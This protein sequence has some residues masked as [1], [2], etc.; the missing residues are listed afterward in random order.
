MV[1]K[2]VENDIAVL[3]ITNHND[4]SSVSVFRQVA[5]KRGITIFPGF[6]L[7]SQE[8]IHILCLYD[9]ETGEDQL[10]RYLGEFG[11]RQPGVSVELATKSFT[12]ALAVVREQGGL[13]I[14]AHVTNAKGLFKMLSGKSRIKAWQ[15]PDL[16]AIQIPGAVSQLPQDILPIVQNQNPDYR[17]R[18]AAGENLAVAVVNARDVTEPADL[19]N[20]VASCWIKMSEITIEGL[21]QAFLDPDSRI[22]LDSDP[23]PKEHAEIL[24]LTWESGFLDGVT[25]HFNPNLNVL[26]GGRGAGKSTVIESLRYALAQEPSGDDSGKTHDGIV[27]DVL[28]PATKLSLRVRTLRPAPREYL[29][30][31]T[32]P[33]PPT[34]REESGQL[35][36]LQP[37]DILPQVEI[38]GQHEIA[39]VTRSP[40]KRTL[41]LNRFM[42]PDKSLVRR[43]AGVR[44]SLELTRR[45]IQEALFELQHVDQQ[46]TTLPVL[47]EKLAQYQEAGLEDRLQE[48]SLLVREES[49]MDS[50]PER[51]Q[52]FGEA[53]DLLW[54]ELPIN[55]TFLSEKALA[56]L[57][58]RLILAEAV[59][60]LQELDRNLEQ[61][62]IQ[63]AEALGR[64]DKGLA[65]VRENWED[66]KQAVEVEYQRILRDLH[67][68]AV[69]GA[70]FIR[71]RG[72][73]ERLQP[74]QQHRTLLEKQLREQEDRRFALLTEWEDIKAAEF[75]LLD[76]AASYVSRQLR[77]R[78]TIKVTA[79][80]ERESL[81]ETLKEEIGGRLSETLDRIRQLPYLSLPEFVQCCRDGADKLRQ[82]YSIP[83]AQAERL[84]KGTAETL[85]KLE[86]LEL[87]PATE[88][89]LNTAATGEPPVWQALDRLSTGQK[90]TAVLLLLMLES[91]VPLII[92]QPEDDL[93][94]RFITDGVVPGIR[95][96]KR[97]R[98][99]IF[100]THNANIPVLGDAEL[101]LGLTPSGEAYLGNAEI[102]PEHAGSIDAG[103]VRELVEEILEGGKE[104]FETRRLKYGF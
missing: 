46:L 76:R 31:R 22:R 32:V 44:R 66:R 4:V 97:Q 71:L 96:A 8:G 85:M 84:A 98:Q 25:I 33:N 37:M 23:K 48:Q 58:G 104:A 74:L 86:E 63:L 2:A 80:R 17:R 82:T 62:A 59:P 36:H 34:V 6:E 81:C 13:S 52:P 69:D 68:A 92:D 28:R 79:A 19:D 9:H 103:P 42:E 61:I 27:R 60:V 30:E 95:Q 73:I 45:L 20:P 67:T 101:I 5:T 35:S 7:V 26:V 65:P 75:R 89:Q 47:E 38:F 41:L 43:K 39:E 49:V 12:E 14:A 55:L 56:E 90:A 15:S 18:H 3:A 83:L 94:N 91:E 87:L 29:I 72:D 24:S 1:E 70:D 77:N 16:S 88:I 78:V 102:R 21:R 53:L 54:Q 64:A 11:I 51:V 93:D 99:F 100:A 10:E 50:I 57:P 40:E